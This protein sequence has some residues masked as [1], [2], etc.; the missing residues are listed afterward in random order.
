MQKGFREKNLFEYFSKETTIESEFYVSGII[1]TG[2]IFDNILIKLVPNCISRDESITD[3]K[4]LYEIQNKKSLANG[5]LIE[6]ILYLKDNYSD[7]L[8][9]NSVIARY[10]SYIKDVFLEDEKMCIMS[11]SKHS[12][13]YVKGFVFDDNNEISTCTTFG[14]SSNLYEYLEEF[15]DKYS[16]F[17][18]ITKLEDNN[19]NIIYESPLH[20]YRNDLQE[21]LQVSKFSKL[22]K[23]YI[24]WFGQFD[25]CL[26]NGNLTKVAAIKFATQ[27]VMYSK[28]I[29]ACERQA[30]SKYNIVFE[31]KTISYPTSGVITDYVGVVPYWT[32]IFDD[33]KSFNI[34][35]EEI[36]KPFEEVNNI[37]EYF[38]SLSGLSSEQIITHAQTIS[39]NSI[40]TKSEL[41]AI[42]SSK[43]YINKI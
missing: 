4:K 23:T 14:F 40:V 24:E 3:L 5:L 34:N 17:P 21:Q 11:S 15:E 1:G 6:Q 33:A 18:L 13:L 32:T 43:K 10:L 2:S 29:K 7:S 16:F 31:S 39:F 25:K 9:I 8:E 30:F 36:F 22:I 35:G 37:T 41:N 19:G 42:S 38:K 27:M 28:Y 26:R 20:K 12:T